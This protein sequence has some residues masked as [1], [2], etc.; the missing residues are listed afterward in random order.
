MAALNRGS[1]SASID[2][3]WDMLEIMGS[4]G[5]PV[6]TKSSTFDVR[7]LW[8]KKQL[9]TGLAGGFSATV[10]AHDIQIFRLSKPK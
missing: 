1:A 9:H 7:D 3:S 5:T 8:A 10:G 6:V 2:L 4:D